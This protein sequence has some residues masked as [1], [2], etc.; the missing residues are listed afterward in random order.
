[1]TRLLDIFSIVN[2]ATGGN[3]VINNTSGLGAT[4]WN[5]NIHY[6]GMKVMMK[7]SR[8][9]ELALK[10]DTPKEDSITHIENHIKNGGKLGSP[11]LRI[12]IPVEWRTGNFEESARVTGHEGRHRCMTILK[13][14]GDEPIEVHLILRYPYDPKYHIGGQIR[15]RDIKPEWMTAINKE[16]YAQDSYRMCFRNFTSF[17]SEAH[18]EYDNPTYNTQFSPVNAGDTFRVFHGFRDRPD[19]VA[20]LIHGMSGKE[21]ANRAHSYEFN[22]NPQGVFVSLS[23][24][25][26]QRF[27]STVIEFDCT[28][29][30][31][32]APVWPGGS[33]TVQ[34]Q[35]AQYFPR[36]REGRVA[37]IQR[38]KEAEKETEQELSKR[39]D[40]EHV[41][42]SKQ[43]YLTYMLTNSTEYQAL[44]IGH[45]DPKK[46]R[47]VYVINTVDYSKPYI[48]MTPQE[49]LQHNQEDPKK[50][51]RHLFDAHEDFSEQMM[52]DRFA[53]RFGYKNR[54]D[55]EHGLCGM[56]NSVVKSPNPGETFKQEIG[57]W[58][59]PKQIPAAFNWFK[60]YFKVK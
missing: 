52:F 14:F 50:R 12:E 1:M 21:R 43:K 60:H 25:I 3:D 47:A 54:D 28:L 51:D 26:A 36:G 46:I 11:F 31:L 39:D 23:Q 53:S 27:G 34:G 32:E 35:M 56:W 20:A 42:Q 15:N 38:R 17:V 16:L 2:E 24:K 33:Y 57:K 9:L 37:R 48:K 44:F 4:G 45:L 49:F 6:D 40:L 19:A 30:E 41:K 18:H 7:P 55:L 29:D 10:I 8:F 22:N 13:M 59:Y 5:Q 58:M